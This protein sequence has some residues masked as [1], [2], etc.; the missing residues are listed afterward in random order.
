LS[1]TQTI[2][3]Q[4]PELDPESE[5]VIYR[6]AQEA[7]TNVARHSGSPHAHLSLRVQDD[8]L[9]MAVSDHGVGLSGDGQAG[10]GIRGMRERA[11]LIGA[12]LQIRS[13]DDGGCTVLLT[14]RAQPARTGS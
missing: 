8:G 12:N 6:V 7:L 3:E 5:L 1:V 2:D 10:A 9:V 13:N 11:A 14:V 4:L